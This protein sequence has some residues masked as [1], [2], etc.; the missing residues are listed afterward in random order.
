VPDGVGLFNF[1]MTAART[2]R[3]TFPAIRTN[4]ADRTGIF[5]LEVTVEV[6]ECRVGLSPSALL[7]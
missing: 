7:R 5:F 4:E 3:K 2:A 6:L 1:D